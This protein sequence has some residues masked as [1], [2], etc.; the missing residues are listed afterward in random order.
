MCSSIYELKDKSRSQSDIQ[1]KGL[2]RREFIAATGI[3]STAGLSLPA[4][5]STTFGDSAGKDR[6]QPV[7]RRL[8]VQPVFNCVIYQRKP[9]TSWRWTGAIQ[10]EQELRE[11]ASI[12]FRRRTKAAPD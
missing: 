10:N 9:A 3:A 2:S 5:V 11:D 1:L 12:A 8:K 4:L 6:Q 7:F